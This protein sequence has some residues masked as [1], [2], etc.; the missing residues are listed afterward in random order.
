MR[1]QTPLATVAVIAALALV[2]CGTAAATQA[3]RTS[4]P[5]R[6]PASPSASASPQFTDPNGET[7][8]AADSLGYCGDD[9]PTTAP[10]VTAAQAD[11]TAWCA[12]SGYSDFTTVES[13]MGQLS[14]D[15]GN[16]DLIA[17]EQDG[18]QLFGDAS[19]AGQNLPPR[20][21]PHA[22]GYG[23][24]MGYL[25]IAGSRASNGNI[26]GAGSASAALQLAQPYLADAQ[27][28]STSC[29]D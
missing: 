8:P 16:N 1:Y 29:G 9:D 18:T 6:A 5:A 13:D 14:T 20:S 12:G 19:T 7:C 11:L 2:G 25:L 26:S 22:F 10:P 24:Y 27:A 4:A 3:A 15:S 17:V 21:D 28:V 23:I